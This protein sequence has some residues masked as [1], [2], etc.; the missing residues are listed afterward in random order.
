MFNSIKHECYHA[1]HSIYSGEIAT[2]QGLSVFLH[3]LSPAPLFW[4]GSFLKSLLNLLQYCFCLCSGFFFF[5]F[6]PEV[7]EIS[8]SQPGMESSLPPLEDTVL[9]TGLAGKSLIF[10]FLP[11]SLHHLHFSPSSPAL[12]PTHTYTQAPTHRRIFTFL[13]EVLHSHSV[14][15]SVGSWAT[16]FS[17]F[18]SNLYHSLCSAVCCH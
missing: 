2:F 16:V 13:C 3:F 17:S 10:L 5:F 6:G 15:H 1:D 18:W 9:T 8:A 12:L 4:C 14:S 7:R 11:N